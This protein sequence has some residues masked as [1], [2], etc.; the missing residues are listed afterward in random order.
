MHRLC[1]MLCIWY[2]FFKCNCVSPSSVDVVVS[3]A[4]RHVSLPYMK[5]KHDNDLKETDVFQYCLWWWDAANV[6]ICLYKFK[7]LCGAS[8][9]RTTCAGIG[10]C[11]QT[12]YCHKEK[13]DLTVETDLLIYYWLFFSLSLHS[14]LLIFCFQCRQRKF[15]PTDSQSKSTYVMRH[16]TSSS[17]CVSSAV[18]QCARGWRALHDPQGLCTKL[19]GSAFTAS[20]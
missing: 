18:R 8:K 1:C 14:V 10:N 4:R 7:I 9:L 20:A 11:A 16:L 2:L 17:T 13:R 15:Y 5:S 6:Y 12:P 19:P 3:S